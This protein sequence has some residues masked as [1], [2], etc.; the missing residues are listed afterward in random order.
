MTTEAVPRPSVGDELELRVESLAFG[1]AGVART[2]PPSQ[3][4]APAGGQAGGYVVFVDG[5]FPGDLVRARVHHRKRAYA[6][7]RAIELLEPGADRVAALAD[8][9]GAPWQELAYARQLEIKQGQVDEA[10]RR[11]GH[12][13]GFELAP[14][15]AAEQEWRY[16]NKLEYSFGRGED[17]TLLCGF[18]APGS[19]ERIQPIEDCL[20]ASPRGNEARRDVLA[21]CR[22]QRLEPFDRR[23]HTGFLRN[24]VVREGRRTGQIQL[25]LITGPGELDGDSLA[26][27][28]R[29]EGIL[30]TRTDALSE[31]TTG[32]E[33]E[34][35]AG[36]E[37]LEE[38]ICGLDVRISPE[39]FFQ[40]N[41]E[42]A[43]R[44]YGLAGDAC[45]LHGWECVFDLFCG[46]GTIGLSLA[47]R[48]GHVYGLEISE[49]AVADAIA[50][51]AR[52]EVTNTSFFAG[53]VR[54]AMRELRERAGRPDVVVVDPPRA[55]LSAKVVRRIIETAPKRIVY[56]SCNPTT[57]APNAAQLVEAGWRLERVTPVDMFPQTPHIECV[58]LLAR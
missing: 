57:L 54:L 16:R 18:H 7:A 9:P 36:V 4:A 19:W 35:I 53:D 46:A 11:I 23:E 20:L 12:L 39:A 26:A 17:G 13:D 25:R 32:G 8:H 21:W 52:N 6:Q 37:T 51:A 14:I 3:G 34:L 44:L 2:N 43:E 50:N 55:G 31:T 56:V 27:A 49:R 41:T 24:L 33:T 45:E 30:W 1:G 47:S 28:V 22:E 48:A 42:M 38:R 15:L 40:T 10:L 5:A 58:A 29:A